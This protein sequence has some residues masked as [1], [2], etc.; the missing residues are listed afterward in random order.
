[1]KKKLDLK[2][3]LEKWAE[4]K[5][6]RP[7]DFAKDMGYT[8]SYGWNLLRGD[9]EFTVEALGRFVLAYGADATRELLVSAGATRIEGVSTLPRPSRRSQVVPVVSI[10]GK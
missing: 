7:T 1:M 2:G 6:I 9:A 10:S 5:Q 4:K 3:A 8:A